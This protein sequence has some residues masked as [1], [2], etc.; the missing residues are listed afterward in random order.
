LWFGLV[1]LLLCLSPMGMLTL[2]LMGMLI[3]LLML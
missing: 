2:T 1:V 3:L